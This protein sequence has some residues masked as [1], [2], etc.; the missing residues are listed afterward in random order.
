M[1]RRVVLLAS[2]ALLATSGRAWAQPSVVPA[3]ELRSGDLVVLGR[4]AV[5][6]GVLAGTLVAVGGSVRVVGRVEKDVIAFGGDVVV[7]AGAQ[8]RGDLLAIGGE[9]RAPAGPARPVGGRVLT[10]GQLEA[11]FATELQ[12]SPLAA[13]PAS[14]LLLAFRL[15]L[16]FLWLVIGLLLVRFVPRPVSAAA[17]FLP[18]R[19]AT[20]A[21]LGTA[22]VLSSL[23][24]SAFLLLVLPAM[25][26]LVV[27]ALVLAILG[28]A[29]TFGL[30]AVF[31]AVGRR[32]ARG[33]TR[34]S[35]LF[36]D[37]AALALGLALLGIL[38][39]VPVAGPL[40]WAVAS[41]LGIGAALVV[42]ARRAALRPAF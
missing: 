38:S 11:A 6:E 15:V 16:L 14:G 37:P 40:V 18:G 27:T 24:V 31:V 39:L 12:T 5:V 3:G 17:G 35:P 26:G 21:A 42:A 22:G 41:L 13:R 36:G 8:I 29:K 23:L 7:E 1:A 10:V 19:L 28:V 30:A 34:G 2:F 4:G 25:A 32:L 20:V 9:V 33:A